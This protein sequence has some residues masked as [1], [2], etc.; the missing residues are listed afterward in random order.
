[1]SNF[2]SV[3]EILDFAIAREEKANAFY[4]GLAQRMDKPWMS[5]VFQGFAEQELKHKFKLERVKD[6]KI[7]LP[8]H[9]KITDLKIADYLVDVPVSDDMSYQDALTVAMKREK[10]AFKLYMDLARAADDEG[11]RGTFEAMAQEE[12]AH[13]LWFEVQY[14]E[15][16][17]AED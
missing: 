12:A 1:M 16:I 4:L 2:G 6:G 15:C 3:D 7:L 11:L 10:S 9:Q 17:L 8:S 5:E 13:K 14:D